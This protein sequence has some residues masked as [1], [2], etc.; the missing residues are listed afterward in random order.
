MKPTSYQ[1][2]SPAG[3]IAVMVMLVICAL[4][5]FLGVQRDYLAAAGELLRMVSHFFVLK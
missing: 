3:R 2:L 4:L 5:H 1:K